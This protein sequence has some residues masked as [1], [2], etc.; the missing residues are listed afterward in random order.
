[1]WILAT[2][3]LRGGC[4]LFHRDLV[5]V[6]ATLS[7]L[8]FTYLVDRMFAVAHRKNERSILFRPGYGMIYRYFIKD[9]TSISYMKTTMTMESEKAKASI[10]FQ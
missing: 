3:N 7:M 2:G 1:M 5:K 6:R 8:L 4:A 9:F 10:P